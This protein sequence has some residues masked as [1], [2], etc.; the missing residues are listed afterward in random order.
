MEQP[1]SNAPI[2]K[3]APGVAGWF[4][5]WINAITKPNEQTFIAMTDHPEAVSRTAFIWIFLATTVSTIISG[6]V[7]AI[8]VAAGLSPAPMIP[9][10]EQFTG[11]TTADGGSAVAGLVSSVCA[12]PF[13]GL[14]AVIFFA[15]GVAL[16]QWVAKLFGGVGTFDKLAY[17]LGAISVPFTLFSTIL[18]PLAAIPYAVFCTIPL[19]LGALLY[20]VVLEIMAVKGI[21]RFGWGQAVGSVLIPG[22][23][24]FALC[25]CVVFGLLALLGPAI[26][27]VFQQINSSLA[28]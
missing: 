1:S 21:N 20:S 28:P 12:A 6:L 11:P 2:M 22:A 5:V 23:A 16:I 8:L 3:P 25:F 10:L 18:S 7:S 17:A 19:S 9:G 26:S 14:F 24:I 15:I 4:P 13:A 27:D